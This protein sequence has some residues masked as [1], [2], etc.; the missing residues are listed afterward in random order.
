MSLGQ[1]GFVPRATGPK[2]LCLCAFFLPEPLALKT[3]ELSSG[4]SRGSLRRVESLKAE[5]AHFGA[6]QTGSGE[7][8]LVAPS[9]A[10]VEFRKKI[11]TME[12]SMKFG[13]NL[14]GVS[15]GVCAMTTCF[16]DNKM[17]TFN[18]LLSWRFQ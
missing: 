17:S 8:P 13:K 6:L 11:E 16:L 4:A 10:L 5:K 15:L 7:P 14:N 18:I 3:N 12:R 1:S 2:S 9:A